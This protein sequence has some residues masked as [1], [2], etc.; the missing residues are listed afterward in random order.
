MLLLIPVIQTIIFQ[1]LPVGGIKIAFQK[2]NIYRPSASEWVGL[3]NFKRIFKGDE[4][5][6]AIKNTLIVSVYS[7]CINFP[8][9]IIFALLLNEILNKVFKKVVQTITYLPHFLSWIAVVGLGMQMFSKGG[10][11]NDLVALFGGERQLFLSKQVLFV[12]IALGIA[13]WKE[14][15]WSSVLYLAAISGVDPNLH[16]AATLDGAN[17]L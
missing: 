4:L 5:W 17:R 15:G 10:T 9:K 14:L 12:P 7:L 1:Y 8:I 3:D 11:I 13:M 2:Y 6:E 16:E